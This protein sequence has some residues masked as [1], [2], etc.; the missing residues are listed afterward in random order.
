MEIKQLKTVYQT[1]REDIIRR[2]NAIEYVGRLKK[3]DNT[4]VLNDLEKEQVT[5][6]TKLTTMI[7]S[8]KADNVDFSKWG[9]TDLMMA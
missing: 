7:K 6:R 5:D 1:L 4:S 9:L 8:L 2:D 3:T